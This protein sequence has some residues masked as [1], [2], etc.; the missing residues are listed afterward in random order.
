VVPTKEKKFA[1]RQSL[2]NKE[3]FLGREFGE[4]IELNNTVRK[5]GEMETGS[6]GSRTGGVELEQKTKRTGMPGTHTSRRG[7]RRVKN[8]CTTHLGG[9]GQ[10]IKS[11]A[12]RKRTQRDKKGGSAKPSISWDQDEEGLYEMPSRELELRGEK[13]KGKNSRRFGRGCTKK[14]GGGKEKRAQKP[15]LT[16]HY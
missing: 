15:P 11:P 12:T 2:G 1:S 10:K 5:R 9:K 3:K 8:P 6:K 14:N 4:R 13:G 7:S 16:F